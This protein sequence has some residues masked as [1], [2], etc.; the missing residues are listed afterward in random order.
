MATKKENTTSTTITFV[1]EGNMQVELDD[2]KNNDKT[3][4]ASGD[5]VY[6]K[7]YCNPIDL[8]VTG[9]A[10]DGTV[11]ID[12][13]DSSDTQVEQLTFTKTSSADLGKLA[14]PKSYTSL[15]WLGSNT[16]TSP[17]ISASGT[18]LN[19]TDRLIAVAEIE[20][21]ATYKG[22]NLSG[23]T[24]P[25]GITDYPVVVVLTGTAPTTTG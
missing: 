8:T 13:T 21:S 22:G 10:S 15:K 25:A 9:E 1:V 6:F 19:V 16:G 12:S 4:F 5:T 3:Q 7:V 14:T 2:L 23:V 17:A 24:I 11:T 20:Y 18:A